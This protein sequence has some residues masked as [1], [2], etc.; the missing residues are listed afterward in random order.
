MKIAC[1]GLVCDSC[2][3]LLATREKNKSHQKEMRASIADQCNRQY[4]MNL[5]QED[6]ND[7]DGCT[8]VN[9]RLFSGCYNCEIRRCVGNKEIE[10]CAFCPDYCCEILQKHFLSDP[11]AQVRLEEIRRSAGIL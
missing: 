6:I 7:C 3:I 5:M 10:N 4:G 9:G 2:P 1:C 8:T 11:E